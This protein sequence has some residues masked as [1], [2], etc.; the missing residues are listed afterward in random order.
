MQ[1]LQVAMQASR[2]INNLNKTSEEYGM[3]IN[4]KKRKEMRISRKEG[5]K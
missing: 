5:G 3:N 1:L 2:I 4:L